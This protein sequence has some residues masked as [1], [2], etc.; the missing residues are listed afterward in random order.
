MYDSI[1]SHETK[2]VLIAESLTAFLAGFHLA[3]DLA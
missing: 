3:I 1:Q 2:D